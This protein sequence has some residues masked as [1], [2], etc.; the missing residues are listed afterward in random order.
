MKRQRHIQQMKEYNENQQ[1][2]ERGGGRKS[3]GKTVQHKNSQCLGNKWI[4]R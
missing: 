3:T 1:T 4:D 2:S